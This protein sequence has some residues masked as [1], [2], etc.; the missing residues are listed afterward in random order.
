MKI[1]FK[2]NQDRPL[3]I[4]DCKPMDVVRS[5]GGR[6][7]LVVSDVEGDVTCGGGLAG[8]PLDTE[9]DAFIVP[10]ATEVDEIVGRLEIEP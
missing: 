1:E 4:A 2:Q 8:A 9:R 3:T 10:D 6:Y 7:Y 5:P